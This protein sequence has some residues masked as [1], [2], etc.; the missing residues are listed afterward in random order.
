[1]N[2]SDDNFGRALKQIGIGDHKVSSN[3]SLN[4]KEILQS[5]LRSFGPNQNLNSNQTSVGMS[6]ATN[7]ESFRNF[8]TYINKQQQI[9]KGTKKGIVMTEK[10]KKEFNSGYF[11]KN[12]KMDALKGPGP[13]PSNVIRG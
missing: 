8:Q 5:K 11:R 10:N 13:D 3:A 2:L 4:P 9:K 7:F 12:N 1:M 6:F